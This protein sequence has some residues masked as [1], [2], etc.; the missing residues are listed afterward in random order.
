MRQERLHGRQRDQPATADDGHPVAHPLHLGQH[1]GREEHRPARLSPLVEQRQEGVLHERVEP[2]GRFVQ[3]GQLGVVL[4][5]LDDADL[6]AHAPGVVA[7][8]TLEVRVGELQALDERRP[9]RRGPAV[10]AGQVVEQGG[11]RHGVVQRDATRQ[12]AHLAPDGDAV[13]DDVV[14]QDRRRAR[15]S[16]AGSPAGSGWWCSCRRHW[17]P[18]SRRSRPGGHRYRAPRGRAPGC[19]G[20]AARHPSGSACRGRWCAGPR[21][22]PSTLGVPGGS[23]SAARSLEVVVPTLDQTPA[24]GQQPRGDRRA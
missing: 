15:R 20:G 12:V 10:Q 14:A 11:A 24:D 23:V 9:E 5:R 17:A 6:L 7:D 19:P 18:G 22:P 1:V 13:A 3:D 16:D 4:E 21:H 2:L 8:G